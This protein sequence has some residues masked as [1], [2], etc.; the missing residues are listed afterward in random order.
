MQRVKKIAVIIE[1]P[2]CLPSNKES[3]KIR[4]PRALGD[5]VA[6]FAGSQNDWQ[7]DH[8]QKIPSAVCSGQGLD[9][10]RMDFQWGKAL[11]GNSVRPIR[12]LSFI[13]ASGPSSS[14]WRPASR[15]TSSWVLERAGWKFNEVEGGRERRARE[16][17]SFPPPRE[18]CTAWLATTAARQAPTPWG[19]CGE[20]SER[21][22]RAFPAKGR[23]QAAASY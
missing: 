9:R 2:S 7:F 15:K 22:R 6:V 16:P 19:G 21:R 13:Q 20:C 23:Q 5:D 14:R 18:C 12:R 3:R 10:L 11:T 4:P 17:A 1:P 8:G